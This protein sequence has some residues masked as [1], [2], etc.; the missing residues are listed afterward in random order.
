MAADVFLFGNVARGCGCIWV[1]PGKVKGKVAH[2]YDGGV[3][4]GQLPG[5]GPG[6]HNC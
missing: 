1:A 5:K 4:G 3:Y 2:V 6:L